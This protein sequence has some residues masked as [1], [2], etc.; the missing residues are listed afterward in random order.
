MVEA[1]I[2]ISMTT[3][4]TLTAMFAAVREQSPSVSYT[5]AIM[6]GF[7]HY[8]WHFLFSL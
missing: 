8:F 4:L 2:G 3:V 1:R 6:D 5:M 7:L